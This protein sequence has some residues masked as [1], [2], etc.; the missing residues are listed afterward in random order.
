MFIFRDENGVGGTTETETETKVKPTLKGLIN[1]HGLQE[2]LNSMIA[3]NRRNLTKQNTELV[4]QL[5]QLK[6]NATLSQ[7][8]SD[9]LQ[10]KITQL[11]E[12]YMSKEELAKRESNKQQKQFD[13]DLQ[14]AN[15]SSKKWENMY[16]NSTI[17][18]AI[19]DAA[20]ENGAIHPSQIVTELQGKTQLIEVDGN[21]CPV[22]KFNDV[23]DDG[24]NVTLD[25]SPIEAVKRMKE[26]TDR[27]GNL[28]KGTQA[29][30]LGG[31]GNTK[32]STGQTKLSELMADPEVYAKWRKE[33]PNLDPTELR[34]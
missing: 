1:E 20:V 26:L 17:Q 11:E 3:D 25:L 2:E 22:V 27:H 24:K 29:S 10:V 18:R 9:S 7:E 28:F 30:G 19:Y 14:L 4:T 12:Q 31:S 23:D 16:S 34:S 6:K 5:E 33:N 8:D 13:T 21:Y 32:G 15:S